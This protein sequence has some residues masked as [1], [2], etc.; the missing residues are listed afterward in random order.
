MKRDYQ[1]VDRKDDTRQLAKFI[2]AN[3]QVLMPMVELIENAQI[4]VHQLMTKLGRATL[5]AVLEISAA[6]LAGENHQGKAVGEIVRHGRQSG[7]VTL[8]DRKV[9]VD[10]PRLRKREGGTGA[11]VGIP[12]Y[13]AMKSHDSL[14]DQVLN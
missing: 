14:G 6:G 9:H 12:A 13:D 3:G 7:T 11:E 5:E 10:R 1:I 2:A 8:K 4:S